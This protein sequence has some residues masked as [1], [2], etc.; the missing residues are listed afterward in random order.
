M[1]NEPSVFEL[2]RFDCTVLY[3]GIWNKDYI[4]LWM[5]C[6]CKATAKS[7]GKMRKGPFQILWMCVL[8]L[9]S[10]YY[11]MALRKVF[12]DANVCLTINVQR[13]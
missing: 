7:T 3:R 1:V 10:S 6:G 13:F 4:D 5:Y 2:L 8:I 12:S 11:P 9:A